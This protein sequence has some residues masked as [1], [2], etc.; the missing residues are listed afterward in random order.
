[1]TCLLT[2]SVPSSGGSV[3]ALRGLSADRTVRHRTYRISTTNPQEEVEALEL[4]KQGQALA[5]EDTIESH[6]KAIAKFNQALK[7]LRA[8]RQKL[9]SNVANLFESQLLYLLAESENALGEYQSQLEHARQA[10][11]LKPDDP[12]TLIN[13]MISLGS[14][15]SSLGQHG[16]ALEVQAQALE[17]INSP[18]TVLD[19]DVAGEMRSAILGVMCVTHSYLG[20]RRK[21]LDACTQALNGASS[22]GKMAL[23]RVIAQAYSELGERNKAIESVNELLR[24]SR[25]S[26]NQLREGDALVT[27]GGVYNALG[28]KQTALDSYKRA[29]SIMQAVAGPERQAQALAGVGA[30]NADL[31]F[32]DEALNYLGQALRLVKPTENPRFVANVLGYIGAVR[33]STGHYDQALKAY[34]TALALARK[35]TIFTINDVEAK[36]LLKIGS[37]YLSLGDTTKG[38]NYLTQALPAF[39]KLGDRDSQFVVATKVADAV[40]SLGDTTRAIEFYN[41]A[42]E[43][44]RKLEGR[45]AKVA[46]LFA[47]AKVYY[48]SGD[49]ARTI[50][51]LSQAL[52]VEK[53]IGG[54]GGQAKLLYSIGLLHMTSGDC[55]KAMKYFDQALT[56]VREVTDRQNEGSTLES[57]ASCQEKAGKLEEALDTYLKAI[58][59]EEKVRTDSQVN[60]FR[61]KLSGESTFAYMRA[62]LVNMRLG[63]KVD[64]FNLSE[65]ARA[66]TFLDQL[67]KGRVDL[68][69]GGDSSLVQKEQKLRFE[70]RDMSQRL[71]SERSKPQPQR[72]ETLS[73][74]LEK[75]LAAKQLEYESFLNELEIQNLEYGSIV[76]VNPLDIRGVQELLDKDTTLISF[77][78]TEEKVL[79]FV[80]THDSFDAVELQV[81][82]NDLLDEIARFRSFP[83]KNDPYPNSLKQL[84]SMLVAPLEHYIKTRMVGIVPHSAL[85]YVPFAALCKDSSFF[86]DAHTIFYLPSASVLPFVQQKRKPI[87]GRLLIM[88]Q[89]QAEGFPVLRYGKR[90]A[91]DVASLYRTVA[92]TN[93]R[94]TE[95]I[96]RARAGQSSIVLLV[97]HGKFNS[98]SPLFSQI[99]LSPDK[100]ND[101]VLEVHEVYGLDLKNAGLVVLTACN[102]ALGGHTEGDDIVG[103]NRAF[104]YAGTPTVLAT[105]WSVPEESTA[106]LTRAFFKQLKGGK[107]KVE[108]LQAAQ[109]EVKKKYPN[110][111]YWAAFVLTGDPGTPDAKIFRRPK[112]RPA[113]LRNHHLR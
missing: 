50:E 91:E 52:D 60:E 5:D 46:T 11:A 73:G 43:I 88:A 21:S 74:T 44:G 64:A 47:L 33:E 37:L 109:S 15:L 68:R 62:V 26:N 63:R 100:A 81:K 4:L 84:Y 55:E 19:K 108:A 113:S 112:T 89:D 25:D 24:L 101:G 40:D 104:I 99:V 94:A 87:G 48:L 76:G 30:V 93:R 8:S 80:A 2:S 61:M 20:D 77:F 83:N 70:L 95:S 71:R 23:L 110:P 53:E 66:R 38:V 72:S 105:L 35:D 59:V 49:N 10:L 16:E 90:L 1:M 3:L 79:A 17:I 36:L 39:Q 107:S 58:N 51:T 82:P 111:Y 18:T 57:I 86:G 96:L 31:G 22:E 92:F 75:Q 9:E 103:L 106:D 45:E 14:A 54:R 7:L 32:K 28:D 41:K 67:A 27:M 69:R 34:S 78:L 42:V 102:T 29:L 6:R 97:A 56:F 98:A 85:H 12:E 65:R 13:I